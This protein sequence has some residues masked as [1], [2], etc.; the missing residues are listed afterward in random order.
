V[1]DLRPEIAANLVVEHVAEYRGGDQHREQHADLHAAECS[2]RAGD[3]EQR[4]SRQEGRHH[5]TRF[6]EDDGEENGVDPLPVL[7]H[8]HRQVLVEVQD[9]VDEAGQV[10]HRREK[11]VAIGKARFYRKPG[12]YNRPMP[13]SENP[14]AARSADQPDRC[15]R[16]RRS[17]GVGAQGTARKRPRRRQFD[18]PDPA[19][20][21]WRQADPRQ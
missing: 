20:R 4:V 19:R 5:E 17:A 8:Q 16:S 2:Q 21:R 3:E 15:R 11:G 7:L 1:E 18:D 6:A 9:D 10:F 12:R 13:E 14:P